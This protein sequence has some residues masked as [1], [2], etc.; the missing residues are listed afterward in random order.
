MEEVADRLCRACSGLRQVGSSEDILCLFGTV[1]G[2]FD[3]F[4]NARR[5]HLY[6][7]PFCNKAPSH[8]ESWSDLVNDREVT[9]TPTECF[10][11]S[12]ACP[13]PSR[14]TYTGTTEQ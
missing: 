13:S 8:P 5:R 10:R 3:R 2:G 9:P 7:L 11:S 14:C 1:I 4:E 12:H 6:S